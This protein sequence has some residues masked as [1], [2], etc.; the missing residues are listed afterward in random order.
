MFNGGNLKSV[1]SNDN[2]IVG[3]VTA[4]HVYNGYSLAI[5]SETCFSGDRPRVLHV[6]SKLYGIAPL[7]AFL[8]VS[9]VCDY[10]ILKFVRGAVLPVGNQRDYPEVPGS[11]RGRLPSLRNEEP[12]SRVRVA[13]CDVIDVAPPLP[14]LPSNDVSG[15]KETKTRVGANLLHLA[16][17]PTTDTSYEAIPARATLL[18]ALTLVKLIFIRIKGTC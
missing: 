11:N 9:V 16:I 2:S 15:R 8:V 3:F 14:N 13:H 6:A 17:K 7:V 12:P 18:S 1:S 10:L 4:F 5:V